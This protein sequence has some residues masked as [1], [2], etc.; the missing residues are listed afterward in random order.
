MRQRR[1]SPKEII[2]LQIHS[3]RKANWLAKQ[4]IYFFLFESSLKMQKFIF[5]LISSISY[6]KLHP[7][8]HIILPTCFALFSVLIFVSIT[9][10]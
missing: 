3:F 1:H 7:L 2:F 6:I 4:L 10:I 8:S 9:H 5:F